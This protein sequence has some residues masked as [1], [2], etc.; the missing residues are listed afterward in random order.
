MNKKPTKISLSRISLNEIKVESFITE[1]ENKNLQTLNGGTGT[2]ALTNTRPV[3]NGSQ[4][5]I[6]IIN[7]QYASIKAA[8]T[9]PCEVAALEF[10]TK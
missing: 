10:K 4:V 6:T 3:L 5:V 7:T 1:I 8:I 2:W 9:S